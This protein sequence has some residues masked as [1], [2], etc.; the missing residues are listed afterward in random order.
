MIVICFKIDGMRKL[1]IYCQQQ[2]CS[3]WSV[4][5]GDIRFMP[6]FVGV[7]WLGGVKWECGRRK[8]EFSL[9]ITIGL[10]SVRSS[11]LA[12]HIEIYTASRGFLA[13]ARL[14][15]FIHI[16]QHIS[17]PA[18]SLDMK[19]PLNEKRLNVAVMLAI[20][21][22]WDSLEWNRHVCISD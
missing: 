21:L 17:I 22:R 3:Q 7:R 15:C 2:R 13:I 8:C 5:S 19:L 9:S 20:K 12:L 10:S 18:D 1:R 16:G 4:L 6:I 14:L 11:P